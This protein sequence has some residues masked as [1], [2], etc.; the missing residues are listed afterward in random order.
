M[1]KKKKDRQEEPDFEQKGELI[2]EEEELE[3]E[4]DLIP[5]LDEQEEKT[6]PQQFNLYKKRGLDP[7]KL[8][9]HFDEV[10]NSILSKYS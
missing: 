1:M 7:K 2:S 9:A 10:K 6:P 8:P 3:E 5:D 4:K